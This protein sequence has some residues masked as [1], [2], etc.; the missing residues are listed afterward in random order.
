M[1]DS[2]MVPSL[3][4]QP[5]AGDFLVGFALPFR[6]LGVIRRSP[7]LLALSALCALITLASLLGLVIILWRATPGLLGA[8]WTRP[9]AWYARA[10][11]E[12]AQALLFLL[13]AVVGANT[14]PLVLIAPFQDALSEGTEELCGD[15]TAPPFRLGT[16]ARGLWTSLAHTLARIAVLLAGHLVLLPLH[17]V[18]GVGSLTWTVLGSLWTMLWIAAEHVGA[19]MAR[20]FYRFGQVREVLSQRRA[21]ALGFGAA[22][23]VLLW[24]P[25]LNTLLLPL[26]IVGGT[27]LYRALRSSGALPPPDA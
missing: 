26:A 2:S 9:A 7:K 13:L 12:V 18:P 17:L 6:A 23:Y 19:P 10:A 8:L 25:V 3:P 24:V 20:H 21:L 1:P 5:R 11:W 27:L 22:A 4:A 15:F 14:V 16:F